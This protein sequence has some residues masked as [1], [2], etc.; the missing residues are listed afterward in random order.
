MIEVPSA[1]MISDVLAKEVRF[2]S[3][4]TNDL[5]QYALAIDR[6]NESVAYLY[7]PFHPAILRLIQ[8]VVESAGG[9]GI[10]VAI[11]GEMASD[12]AAVPVLIGL[13]VRKLS[14]NSTALPS[15]RSM[16]RHIAASDCA[17]LVK[18]LMGMATAEEIEVALRRWIRD[19]ARQVIQTAAEKTGPRKE[20]VDGSE[21][22]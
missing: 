22:R 10:D 20:R 11:C 9:A 6:G 2:F 17:V 19:R 8:R 5:I 14:M 4:G 1:A 7:Q 12:P 13:G 18:R 16:V 21:D 15:V 3:I